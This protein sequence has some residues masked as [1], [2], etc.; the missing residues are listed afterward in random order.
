MVGWPVIDEMEEG[1]GSYC[2]NVCL[3]AL[4]KMKKT[5]MIAGCLSEARAPD[6]LYEYT[7]KCYPILNDIPHPVLPDK[8]C[9]HH[10]SLTKNAERLICS[11]F[12]RGLLNPFT[13][14]V[15]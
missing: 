6:I 4:L 7:K 8:V 10:G 9:R 15:N 11:L 1:S 12:K 14:S 5:Y 2:L 13:R 3:Q